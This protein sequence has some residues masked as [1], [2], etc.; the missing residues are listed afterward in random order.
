MGRHGTRIRV[1][2][3]GSDHE[4]IDIDQ[5]ISND[6]GESSDKSEGSGS[7]VQQSNFRIAL[8]NHN[9]TNDQ[10]RNVYIF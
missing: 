5:N 7:H 6:S 3:V 1:S 10:L 8:P 4:Y 9:A 2:P